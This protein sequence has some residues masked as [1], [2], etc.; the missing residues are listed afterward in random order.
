MHKVFQGATTPT[1]FTIPFIKGHTQNHQDYID[2]IEKSIIT[3]CLGPAGTGK[4]QPLWSKIKTPKGW[5]NMGDLKVGDLVSTPNGELSTVLQIFKQGIKPVFKITFEDGRYTHACKEHLFNVH[6]YE[7]D[8]YRTISVEEIEK[9]LKLKSKASRLYIDLPKPYKKN[10]K[11]NL[12]LDPYLVGVLLGDGCLTQYVKFS[13]ADQF[14]VDKIN[15][16]IS[17]D[18]SINKLNSKYDYSITGGDILN[19]I[20][21]LNLHKKRSYEKFIP[22][23]YI[24]SD[25]NS[26][27]ELIQGLFDTDGTV[28]KNGCISYC[29]T[30]KQLAE[31][32]QY[33]IRSIGGLCKIKEKQTTYTYKGVK[34]QGRISYNLNIRH[35]EPLSLFSLPRKLERLKEKNQYSENLKLRIKNIEYCGEEDCQCILIDDQKHLYITDDFIVTHNTYMA[36]GQAAIMLLKGKCQKIILTRPVVE[37]GER[38]GFLPGDKDEKMNP[39]LLPLLDVLEEFLG[40]QVVADLRAKGII[41]ICPLAHM[42][43]RTFKNAVVIADELQNATGKQIK[44]L[45]TRL[46]INSKLVLNGDVTQSDLPGYDE[47]NSPLVKIADRLEHHRGVDIIDMEK[48]DIM[49]NPFLIEII[50]ELDREF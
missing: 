5:T 35:K 41:E 23:E 14:I 50:D 12:P 44:M 43:G 18:C 4:A 29:T 26:I 11:I 38:I 22:K 13:S 48:A 2:A 39:Y 46:G 16:K 47:R 17:K 27:I 6:Y 34:K 45:I 3:I 32:V 10:D 31:Q 21:N 30:S 36:A 33:L 42:R 1:S 7:W 24:D 40:K 15:N 9:L 19:H 28:D 20:K 25:Y 8:N 37:C 49:R